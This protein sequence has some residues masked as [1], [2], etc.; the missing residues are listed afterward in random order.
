MSIKLDSMSHKELET[1]LN[2]VKTAIKSAYERDR[3]EARKAAEKAAA[4]FGFSLDEV[5]SGAKKSKGAKAAAKYA[6]PADK[7]QTW[8]GKGRQPN[9]YRELAAKGVSPEELAI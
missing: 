1:L 4:E 2:D 7:T 6:N 3:V 5:S 9:W 8:T